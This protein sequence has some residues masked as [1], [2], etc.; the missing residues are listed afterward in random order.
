MDWQNG[1]ILEGKVTGITKFGAFVAL[2]G[3]KS[4]LVHISEVANTF[5]SN[6]ADFVQMG[7]TVKVMLLNV[8][9]EGKIN[10]SMKRAAGDPPGQAAPARRTEAA[11]AKVSHYAAP[12]PAAAET[13]GDPDFEDRLKKF[14]QESDSR[15]AGSRIYADH[16]QRRRGR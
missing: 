12:Q 15:I 10:L 5:V 11:P 13:S 14:M 3:G 6:V 2:P 7:Q 9:P 4:G 8:T 1:E 16:R